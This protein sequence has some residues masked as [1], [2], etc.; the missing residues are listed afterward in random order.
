M[1]V[2]SH[3]WIA[4]YD[5][6]CDDCDDDGDAKDGDEDS[7]KDSDKDSHDGD[8]DGHDDVIM[9]TVMHDNNYFTNYSKKE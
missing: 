2:A 4:H 5:N 1:D 6:T 7:D 9:M 8:H 3:M